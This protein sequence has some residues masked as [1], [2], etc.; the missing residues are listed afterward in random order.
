VVKWGKVEQFVRSRD[1]ED[2]ARVRRKLEEAIITIVDP[3]AFYRSLDVRRSLGERTPPLLSRE[4]QTDP[5]FKTFRQH[6]A[7]RVGRVLL[8]CSGA[9]SLH[10]L[11]RSPLVGEGLDPYVEPEDEARLAE[12]DPL[13]LAKK[14]R[15]L[16]KISR[17]ALQTT[18]LIAHERDPEQRVDMAPYV[19]G[20]RYGMDTT[21]YNQ[22][23]LE[24]IVKRSTVYDRGHEDSTAIAAKFHE[25]ARRRVADAPLYLS[26]LY[27]EAPEGGVRVGVTA[28]EVE[29]QMADVAAG[30]ASDVL[31]GRGALALQRVFRLVL[32]N[33]FRLDATEAEKLDTER[34]F[35]QR[36]IER[37]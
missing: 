1:S 37:F 24:S 28:E 34:R 11:L 10:A 22:A 17:I 26:G 5:R 8:I 4:V 21:G 32:Y 25:L 16:N 18:A 6:I 2:A 27:E 20:M 19:A 33:G 23:R 9:E 14:V 31:Q 35:H 30:W 12:L 13:E 36:L 7:Q 3:A 29:L 15:D